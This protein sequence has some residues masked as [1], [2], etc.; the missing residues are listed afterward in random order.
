MEVIQSQRGSQCGPEEYKNNDPLR[1]PIAGHLNKTE[2][3]NKRDYIPYIL[4]TLSCKESSLVFK[5]L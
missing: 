5:Y 2:E 1:T 4:H 3:G